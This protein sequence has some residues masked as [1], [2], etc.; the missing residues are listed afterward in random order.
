[1]HSLFW[2]NVLAPKHLVNLLMYALCVSPRMKKVGKGIVPP[3]VMPMHSTIV[4]RSWRGPSI[5]L[6]LYRETPVSRTAVVVVVFPVWVNS[7]INHLNISYPS[8]KI[9]KI[10]LMIYSIIYKIFYSD[11]TN[12]YTETTRSNSVLLFIQS[13]EH[14]IQKL[15]SIYHCQDKKL[16][17]VRLFCQD[18]SD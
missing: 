12:V 9:L 4:L 7:V 15:T 18:S 5:G 10:I 1:M 13:P 8:E 14:F 3:P 11:K 16:V 6:A 17:E 2:W